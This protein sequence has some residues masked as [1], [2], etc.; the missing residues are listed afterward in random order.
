MS[1]P[2]LSAPR[3]VLTRALLVAGLMLGAAL[4]LRLLSPGPEQPSRLMGVL[5]GLLVVLFA[6]AVPK[7]LAPW[8]ASAGCDPAARQRRQR[9]FGWAL[10]LGGLAYALAWLVVPL[11][12]AAVVAGALLGAALVLAAARAVL[13]RG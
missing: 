5:T 1:A 7:A 6:N 2:P 12:A 10:T 3:S 11:G 9:F 8:P 4:A 13:G